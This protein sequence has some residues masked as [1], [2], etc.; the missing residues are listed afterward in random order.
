[1]DNRFF[2]AEVVGHPPQNI[3]R[4]FRYIEFTVRRFP[5]NMGS[6]Y[7]SRTLIYFL[8]IVKECAIKVASGGDIG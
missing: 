3:F 8:L 1:M 5:Q 7:G 2:G 4:S 6:Q